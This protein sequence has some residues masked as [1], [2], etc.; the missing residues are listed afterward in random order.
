MSTLTK[1]RKEKATKVLL[2][3]AV[4]V[5][6]AGTSVWEL[7]A[8]RPGRG[9]PMIW[10]NPERRSLV[11]LTRRELVEFCGTVEAF[12]WSSPPYWRSLCGGLS[13]V[14]R[15]AARSAE[16]I[17]MARPSFTDEERQLYEK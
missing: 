1:P 7:I 9:V 12:E 3:P 14:T 15:A 2:P 6:G 13:R 4:L 17:V 5:A 10:I 8:T 16:A 11:N